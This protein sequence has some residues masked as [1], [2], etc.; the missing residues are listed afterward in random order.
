MLDNQKL[1]RKR[2]SNQP[3]PL[4]EVN[5]NLVWTQGEN[6]S[7][8][9]RL[10]ECG[11]LLPLFCL[12]RLTHQLAGATGFCDTPETL[13]VFRRSLLNRDGSKLPRWKFGTVQ[14]GSELPHSIGGPRVQEKSV[15]HVQVNERDA[16]ICPSGQPRP[17]LRLG[18]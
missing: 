3:P 12:A 7:R 13:P 17:P 15:G 16:L 18:F 10:V 11:S 4:N 6:L 1:K 14:S 8:R 2:A 5:T 9:V